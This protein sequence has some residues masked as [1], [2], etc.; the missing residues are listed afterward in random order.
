[1]PMTRDDVRRHDATPWHL[2]DD[3]AAARPPRSRPT[4]GSPGE[5]ADVGPIYERMA[6]DLGLRIDRGRVL[7]VGCGSG[8]FVRLLL[9]RWTPRE[10]VGIDFVRSAVELLRAWA[11]TLEIPGPTTL[12]FEVGDVTD[13][14]LPTLGAFDVVNVGSV[15]RHVREPERLAAG[16]VNLRRN[17]APGGRIVS[18]EHLPRTTMRTERML[19]RSRDEMEAACAA[20]GLR[21]VDVRP[22]RGLAD[23]PTDLDGPDE[24]VRDH[25]HRVRAD[26]QAL[27]SPR[28]DE[29]IRRLVIAFLADLERAVQAFGGERLAPTDLP[30]PKL[31][32]LATD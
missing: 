7:D 4:D 9:E 13:P 17:L 16:L 10:I 12:R 18:S 26:M 31:V 29:T 25:D 28:T 2:T 30:S 5:D 23:D 24:A 8:R 32:V 3:A 27:L 22:T 11:A 21:I 14:G 6:A 19:V 1:M 15:L 20:A